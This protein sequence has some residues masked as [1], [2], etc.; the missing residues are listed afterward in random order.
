MN[1]RRTL[2]FWLLAG[3]AAA[4]AGLLSTGCATPP[5]TAEKFASLPTGTVHTYHRRSS[6]SL[7]N[8]DGPVVWTHGNSTW[9]GRPV[10]AVSSP[11][12]Q[13]TLHDPVTLAML[14]VRSPSGETLMTYDP[15][16]DYQWPLEVGKTWTSQHRVTRVQAGRTVGVKIDWK[17][18][19]Y[20]QV[21]VPAGTFNAWQLAWVD[22]FGET[23]TRW[24]SPAEGVSTIRRH[25]ERPASHPLG[26]GVL[27][28]E[29]IS[30]SVPPVMPGTAAK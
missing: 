1:A 4:A 25:V 3:A 20:G 23:E 19:S 14:A 7:G 30:R 21:T 16:M 15:P 24:V 2:N 27:D 9:E 18:V 29:L 28:A 12:L 17:V 11:Q 6:G 10:V 22:N 5:P 13:T 26:A 8:F